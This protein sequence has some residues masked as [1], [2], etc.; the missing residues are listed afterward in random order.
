MVYINSQNK[1]LLTTIAITEMFIVIEKFCYNFFIC[2]FSYGVVFVI[3]LN[4]HILSLLERFPI[5]SYNIFLKI[6]DRS[7]VIELHNAVENNYGGISR[8]KISKPT[9]FTLFQNYIK[10]KFH[11]CH[12]T[13]PPAIHPHFLL[14]SNFGLWHSFHPYHYSLIFSP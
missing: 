11:V 5:P 8:S 14:A 13:C 1:S 2:V 9:L 10:R 12:Q 4:Y 6:K 3:L 7:L